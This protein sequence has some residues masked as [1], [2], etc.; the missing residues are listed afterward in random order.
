M[1]PRVA[2]KNGIPIIIGARSSIRYLTGVARC[3]S[4]ASRS[5]IA[6][7]DEFGEIGANWR[8]AGN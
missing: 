1:S 6:V 5:G 4:A 7:L 8:Q 2:A 3:V